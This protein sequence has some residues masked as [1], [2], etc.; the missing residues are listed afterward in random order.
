MKIIQLRD[1][2]YPFFIIKGVWYPFLLK[3]LLDTSYWGCGFE[4]MGNT[5][6]RVFPEFQWLKARKSYPKVINESF[7]RY[8]A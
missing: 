7:F 3:I 5:T 2:W 6:F 4:I 1:V 8:F